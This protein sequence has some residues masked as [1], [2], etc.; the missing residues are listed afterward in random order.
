M[1]NR[2]DELLKENESFAFK[3][4][5]RQGVTKTKLKRHVK[6]DIQ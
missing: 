2:I 5:F 1:L 6:K 3:Q 4:H